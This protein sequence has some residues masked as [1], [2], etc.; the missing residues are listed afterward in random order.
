MVTLGQAGD[1]D[2]GTENKVVSRC[3]QGREDAG[4]A[5][6]EVREKM[7]RGQKEKFP[8]SRERAATSP[9]SPLLGSGA[10]LY[11]PVTT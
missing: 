4:V 5:G 3:R 9:Q 11:R 10:T 8:A 7:R 6:V 2:G 1:G